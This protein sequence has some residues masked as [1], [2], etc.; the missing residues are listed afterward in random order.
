MFS[1]PLVSVAGLFMITQLAGEGVVLSTVS[2]LLQQR[3][4]PSAVVSL[5]GLTLGVASAGGLLLALRS[6]LAG[7]I[8]PLAG[9]LSDGTAGRWPVIAGSLVAGLAG[10]GMLFYATSLPTILWGIVLGAIS[11]GAAQAALA[12]QVG[13]LAPP[14]QEGVVMGAY[15][16][17]GDVGSMAGPFLAFAL[18]S[19]VDLRWV[20]MVCALAFVA[21]LGLLWRL[22]AVRL[23]K[24]PKGGDRNRFPKPSGSETR[25]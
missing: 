12:A 8:G 13:D 20:Y 23:Q 19:V 11:G 14:G 6:A 16:T 5:G 9:H 25:C 17:A 24:D 4:G 18:I 21:G 1:T 22:R 3:F 2:L 7:G 10:F 15:A